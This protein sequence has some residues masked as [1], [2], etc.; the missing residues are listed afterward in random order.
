MFVLGARCRE[1]VKKGV[2]NWFNNG[3]VETVFVTNSLSQIPKQFKEPET[4]Q[5]M[6]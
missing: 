6:S 5:N 4:V 3:R 1:C 2:M